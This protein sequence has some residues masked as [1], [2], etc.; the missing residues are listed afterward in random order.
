MFANLYYFVAILY[1]NEE[2]VFIY[3]I[4]YHPS[5]KPHLVQSSVLRCYEVRTSGES[6]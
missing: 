6:K 4:I 1:K 3:F 2:P 5:Q